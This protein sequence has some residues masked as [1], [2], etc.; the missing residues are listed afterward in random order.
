MPRSR[1]ARDQSVGVG[2]LTDSM[3]HD[4]KTPNLT[5]RPGRPRATP[6]TGPDVDTREAILEAA[7]R[8]FTTRGYSA[9][10]TRQIADA[11]GLR[12]AS[13][14]HYFPRKDD[15]LAE[16]LDRTVEPALKY[17]VALRSASGPPDAALFLLIVNDLRSFCGQAVKLG[18][19]YI[20]PDARAERFRDFWDKRDRLR[21]EYRYFIESG[22]REGLFETHDVELSTSVVFG[23]VESV[24]TWFEPSSSRPATSVWEAVAA[25]S[26][27]ML[28]AKPARIQEVSEQATQLA[29][30]IPRAEA[31]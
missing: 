11:V 17:A 6:A 7:G 13:L 24:T 10:S 26:L 16:L 30:R 1:I 9:S 22:R 25:S 31:A 23:I 21:D 14:F 5:R 15:M 18:W 27:R 2:A 4:P 29:E 19:L 20:Q 3:K 8:L 28:L 12:Q